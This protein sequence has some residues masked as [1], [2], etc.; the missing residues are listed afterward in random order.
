M[1]IL[2][3]LDQ[4]DQ[5]QKDNGPDGGRDQTPDQPAGEESKRPEEPASDESS[6]HTND[7]VS[8]EAVAAT[9]HHVSGKPT[10]DKTNN[11]KPQEMHIACFPFEPLKNSPWRELVEHHGTKPAARASRS[12]AAGPERR[13]LGSGARKAN[14]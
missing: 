14:A 12:Q 6:N 13:R 11:E 10:G 9:P 2:R 5:V 1:A 3:S 7:Q 4:S 8:D